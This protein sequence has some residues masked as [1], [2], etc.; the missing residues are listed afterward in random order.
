MAVERIKQKEGWHDR[1]HKYYV[2]YGH[3]LLKSDTFNHDISEEFADSLLRKDLLQKM[4]R[5][6]TIW[7]GFSSS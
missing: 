6:R 3:R 4:Q 5:V 1:R 2:G 7:K